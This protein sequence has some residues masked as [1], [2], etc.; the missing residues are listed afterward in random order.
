MSHDQ[1][2][3]RRLIARLA[4]AVMAADGRV[5]SAEL[6]ALSRFD[7]LGLGP[8]RDVAREE[9][10]RALHKRI[11]VAETCSALPPLTHQAADLL[12]GALAD[13]AASDGLLSPREREMFHLVAGHL[14]LDAAAAARVLERALAATAAR[15]C[16][17]SAAA[18]PEGDGRG[19]EVRW[20]LAVLGVEPDAGLLSIDEAFLAGV[21]RYD[22]AKAGVLGP[23]FAALAI[24]RLAAITD[25]YEVAIAAV[26]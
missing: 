22:P 24:R 2:D 12:L 16:V 1:D 20:A 25:A 9:I 3:L 21:Q 18:A 6:D 10:Q 23:E 13:V 8:L 26:R 15:K 14:G 4:L 19:A 5:T 11:D 7:A 17:P